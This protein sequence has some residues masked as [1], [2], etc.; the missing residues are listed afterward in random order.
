MLSQG[1][2]SSGLEN[3]RMGKRY[4]DRDKIDPGA[5]SLAVYTDTN[6]FKTPVF[7]EL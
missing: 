7:L 2:W 5:Y 3:A 6:F 4:N 1:K